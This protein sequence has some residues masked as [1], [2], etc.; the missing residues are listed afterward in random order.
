MPPM[1]R[2]WMLGL[3]TVS[4]LSLAACAKEKELNVTDAYVRYSPVRANPSAAYFTVHGGPQDVSLIGVSTEVAIRSEMHESM[5]ANGMASMKPVMSV[6]VPAGSIV[7]F[8]PGGKHV[9]LWNINPG[10]KPPKRITFTFAFS[11][12]ERIQADAP[13][14]AA[15]DA[16]PGAK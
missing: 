9:M 16:A 13:L 2:P 7:K 10:I 12:G 4:A 5:N 6:P 1:S 8:E 11:N 14:I 15:G 3:A